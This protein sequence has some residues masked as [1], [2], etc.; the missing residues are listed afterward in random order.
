MS[1]TS[2]NEKKWR[3]SI[4]SRK[5]NLVLYA[6]YLMQ[7]SVR[8]VVTAAFAFNASA[9]VCSNYAKLQLRTQPFNL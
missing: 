3:E 2:L 5:T 4:V 9:T 6:M 7:Q 8:I 1:M